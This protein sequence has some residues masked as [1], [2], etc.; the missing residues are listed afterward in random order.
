MHCNYN[1]VYNV[2]GTQCPNLHVPV[3]SWWPLCGLSWKYLYFKG[4]FI[5]ICNYRLDSIMILSTGLILLSL[6]LKDLAVKIRI[7]TQFA[8]KHLDLVQGK[9]LLK[10]Y[11]N[12]EKQ[13]IYWKFSINFM[14]ILDDN[15]FF[16]F[17]QCLGKNLYILESKVML[18]HLLRN[19]RWNQKWKYFIHENKNN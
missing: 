15:D 13:G 6:T 4:Q 1:K 11:G 2:W 14:E 8:F 10:L 18:I 7:L 16:S 9:N 19:F 5:W 12:Y 3:L 17:R